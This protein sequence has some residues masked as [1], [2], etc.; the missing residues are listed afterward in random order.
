M[1]HPSAIIHETATVHETCA[2]WHN[3]NIMNGVVLNEGVSVGGNS[4]IG[5][6]TTVGPFTRIGFGCFI[7]NRTQI[8]SRVFIGP[9]VTMCDD[10]EPY[11]GN[12]NYKAQPPIIEDH[13]SIGAGVTILPNVRIGRYAMVGAGA[14]VTKDVAPDTTVVGN[15]ATPLQSAALRS[16]LR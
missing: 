3:V 1:I 4:E 6:F 11:V 12:P 7:P 15:P 10:K 14:V 9:N 5:R 13:A 8:G 2:I 16:I